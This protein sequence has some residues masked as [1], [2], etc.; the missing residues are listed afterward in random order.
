[1]FGRGTRELLLSH[2]YPSL[3]IHRSGNVWPRDPRTSPFPRLS[4]ASNPP[5]WECLAEGPANF[6]FPTVIPR[7]QST[8]LGMFGRGT[9]EL[10][11]SHGYPSLPIHRSGNVWPRDPRTSPFPRLSLAS[12]PPVWECLAEGPANFSFPTVIPRFQSTGL[13][14]FGRG[15]H[16]LLL[17]HGYPSLPIHRSGNVWPRD[18]RTSPFP[19]LSLASNPPVWECLAEG[20]TNFS[21]PTVIPRFQSTG[22]GMFGR[23]THELLL[24][25]GYPSLPI[26]RSGNVWPRDPRTSPFPRL[27]LASNPPVWECLAEGPTNFSFPTVIP[28]FQSTGLGMFGRGTHE[29]LLSHGY[30]SLPIHRSRNV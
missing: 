29:L 9:R 15:T 24:S 12:N 27:S 28:R 13:G 14:M 30:P 23:G 21:F 6:S 26:H 3:P 20:P 10:L 16:E 11:L 1:M 5:V 4:L 8:G 18:P 25:H 2:G 22:L 19:R 7:F 17:S